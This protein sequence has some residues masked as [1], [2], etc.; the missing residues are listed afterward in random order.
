M[1]V[2]IQGG[3][4]EGEGEGEGGGRVKWWGRW[5]RQRIR[6][7]RWWRKNMMKNYEYEDEN[8]EE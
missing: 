4:G 7:R 3:A 5:R 8:E 2:L 6:I 1:C